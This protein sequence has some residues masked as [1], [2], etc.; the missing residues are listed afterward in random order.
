MN[1]NFVIGKVYSFDLIGI[2]DSGEKSRKNMK[3][4]G[5][6]DYKQAIQISDIMARHELIRQY[7]PGTAHLDFNMYPYILFELPDGQREVIGLTWIESQTIT[8]EAITNV[9]ITISNVAPHDVEKIRVLLSEHGYRLS[10]FTV[11]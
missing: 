2:I 3:C 5:I 10:K 1:Y 7:M 9:H 4:V 8:D 6:L 11:S